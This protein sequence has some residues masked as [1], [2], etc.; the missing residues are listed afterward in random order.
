[1]TDR[2]FLDTNILVYVYDSFDQTK[3]DRAI[4]V[5]DA[6]IQKSLGFGYPRSERGVR[7]I[8]SQSL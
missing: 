5:V 7:A 3:Q 8:A 6:L 1:M 2:V 4:A